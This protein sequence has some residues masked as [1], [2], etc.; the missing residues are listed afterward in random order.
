MRVELP[1]VVSLR[2]VELRQV[3]DASDLHVVGRLHEVYACQRVVRDDACA[4]ASF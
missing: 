2:D 1:S 4:V 3:A